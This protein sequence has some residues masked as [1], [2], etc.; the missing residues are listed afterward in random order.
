MSATPDSTFADSEQLI[1]DLKRQL[2]ESRAERDEVPQ[3]ETAT[4]EISQVI[5]S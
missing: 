1:T 2:A 4:A 3:R 5:N